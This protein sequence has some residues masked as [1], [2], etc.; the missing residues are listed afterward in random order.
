MV[1]V[2]PVLGNFAGGSRGKMPNM[3]ILLRE[4]CALSVCTYLNERKSANDRP[5]KL[6]LGKVL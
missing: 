3:Q 5:N 1:I 4:Q 6:V 2:A